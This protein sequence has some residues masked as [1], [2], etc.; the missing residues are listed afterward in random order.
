MVEKEIDDGKSEKILLQEEGKSEEKVPALVKKE[1]T[2]CAEASKLKA[3][4][5]IVTPQIPK[6][7]TEVHLHDNK[8]L[9]DLGRKTMLT[10]KNF[11]DS[12]DTFYQKALY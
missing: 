1:S 2:E 9:A 3:K 12:V 11:K 7:E 5:E 10:K 4:P 6:E 8:F